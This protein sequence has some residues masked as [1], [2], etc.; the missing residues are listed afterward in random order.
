MVTIIKVLLTIIKKAIRPTVLTQPT[1]LVKNIR[2][3]F[4]RIPTDADVLSQTSGL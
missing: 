3:I 4:F 1:V 2:T